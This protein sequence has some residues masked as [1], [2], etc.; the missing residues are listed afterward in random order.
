M[1]MFWNQG[2]IKEGA[3][4]VAAFETTV[5][6]GSQFVGSEKSFCELCEMTGC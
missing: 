4:S 5:L 2:C 1:I 3:E 6:K